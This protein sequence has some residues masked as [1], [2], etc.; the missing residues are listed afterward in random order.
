MKVQTAPL[1]DFRREFSQ[2]DPLVWVTPAD[3]MSI[4]AAPSVQAVYMAVE[5]GDLNRPGFQGGSL[6]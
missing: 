1:I 3:V 6:V 5:R 4:I 2:L